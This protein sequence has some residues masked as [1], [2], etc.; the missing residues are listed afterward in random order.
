ML[1]SEPG[2]IMKRIGSLQ[3]DS[4]SY[5]FL[6][7]KGAGWIYWPPKASKTKNYIADSSLSGLNTFI[8]RH[9]WN[10]LILLA[11]Y[12]GKFFS[13]SVLC[14]NGAQIE[15]LSNCSWLPRAE[16]EPMKLVKASAL[17][18]GTHLGA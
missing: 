13:G 8:S 12:Y 9:L 10:E 11:N 14:I 7:A 15:S 18:F 16:K 4:F 6:K 2:E 17:S 1:G 3:F 5:K